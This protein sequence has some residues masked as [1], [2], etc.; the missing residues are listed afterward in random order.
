MPIWIAWPPEISSALLNTGP[1]PGALLAAANAWFTM[2]AEYADAAAELTTVLGAAQM[3][4][5]QGPSAESYVA[6]H[7]PYLAWLSQA[8]ADSAAAAA[9]HETTATAYVGAIAAMPTLGELA[10][11]HA[12]H[13][14]LIATNFFGIN[15]IPLALNEAD[16]LRMW[17][18]AAAVMSAYEAQSGLAL[19]ALPPTGPAPAIMT[20]GS[21]ASTASRLTADLAATSSATEAGTALDSSDS[22]SGAI[23]G[24]PFL[25]EAI[26]ALRDFIANPSPSSLLALVVNG[27]LFGAYLSTNVPIYM[28]LT[29]PLWGTA[30]TTIL[31]SLAATVPAGVDQPT[32][33]QPGPGQPLAEPAARM[34]RSLPPLPAAG[35]PAPAAPSAPTPSTATPGSAATSASIAAPAA[36][37]AYLVFA[38]R[39]EPPNHGRG[40]TFTDGSPAGM[41]AAA[42]TAPAPAAARGQQTARRRRARSASPAPEFMDMNV[43]VDPEPQ[44]PPGAQAS[45]RGAGLQG[46]VGMVPT[47]AL[48][49]PAGLITQ[50]S[51][52][53]SLDGTRTTPMLPRT[54]E[55]HH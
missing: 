36:A 42:A 8:S 10:L 20:P 35:A 45:A 30:L 37:P 51:A 16:Y 27:G 24:F 38:A 47:A 39:D 21:E 33:E 26:K 1:G 41:P 34:Q 32:T 44:D 53:G 7:G 49:Q 22:N 46:R 25:G 17:L 11:N 23:D 15:T 48:R 19:L 2:S 6:S 50:D 31:A 3:S 52:A 54:W 12:V 28:A 13:G 4:A 18:Q 40:P 55:H 5:W 29:S 9:Q 43:T 14:A